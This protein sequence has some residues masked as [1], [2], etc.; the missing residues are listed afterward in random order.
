MVEKAAERVWARWVRDSG[1]G[2][3]CERGLRSMMGRGREE[4]GS[5]IVGI[6]IVM[7]SVFLSYFFSW[8]WKGSR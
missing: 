8:V 5:D 6:W 3:G 4:G 7:R 1:V 2:E